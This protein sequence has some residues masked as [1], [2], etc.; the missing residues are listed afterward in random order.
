MSTNKTGSGSLSKVMDFLETLL[1]TFFVTVMIF[2]YCFKIY[3]VKGE[4]MQET[5]FSGDKL[6]VETLPFTKLSQGDI[7]VANISE[8]RLLDDSGDL[9]DK[10]VSHKTIVKRIIACEGQSVDID[11]SRGKVIIDGE[12]LTESYTSGLTHSDEGAFTGKYPVTVPSGYLFVMGDNRRNSLD[13]RSYDIGFVSVDDVVGK[14]VFRIAPAEKAG[15]V[16]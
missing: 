14:V 3:V 7:I 11:F 10:A 16:K 6:I 9:Y 5:L 2:T 8:A 15:R 13:S 4:S 1:I 12:E